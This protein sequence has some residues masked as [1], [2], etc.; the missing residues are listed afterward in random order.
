KQPKV[1]SAMYDMALMKKMR[2]TRLQPYLDKM[3]NCELVLLPGIHC[4]YD[5][6]PD[7]VAD[8]IRDFLDRIEN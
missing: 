4:I 5:Q 2:D 6:R 7:D 1:S 3:G 8:I